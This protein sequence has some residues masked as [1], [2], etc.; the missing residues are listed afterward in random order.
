MAL[1]KLM[2]EDPTFAVHTDQDTGQDD[3]RGH[4]RAP[5]W[6]SVVDRLVREFKRR[7]QRSAKPAGRLQGDPDPRGRR[8]GRF[9]RQTGGH[10]QYGHARSGVPADRPKGIFIFNNK[11][12]G[13]VIPKEFIKRRS[14]RGSRKR[15][16]P[17]RSPGYPVTGVEVDLIFG[18]YHEV[19]SSEIASRSPA[20]CLPG[21]L[22]AGRPVLMEPVMAV[23]VVT[24]GVLERP[25]A[26]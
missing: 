16:R 17:G 25:R 10:G 19:D 2:Q 15:S 11:I 13:G 6:R 22:Q 5:T 7:R 12:V 8:R 9:V 26:R 21:R 20:R 14:S 1:G 3:H 24:R 18:S 23:E 4:G